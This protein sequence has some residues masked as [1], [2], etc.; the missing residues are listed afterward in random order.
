MLAKYICE[1]EKLKQ[2]I[3]ALSA[4]IQVNGAKGE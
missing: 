2:E 1:D 3:E 4:H